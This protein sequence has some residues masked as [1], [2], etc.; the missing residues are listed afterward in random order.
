[1]H[2]AAAISKT[3]PQAQKESQGYTVARN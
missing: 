1:M 2:V 3:V